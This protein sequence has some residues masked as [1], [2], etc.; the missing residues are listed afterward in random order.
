MFIHQ[1]KHTVICLATTLQLSFL[2]TPS[3]YFLVIYMSLLPCANQAWDLFAYQIATNFI[4]KTIK[5]LPKGS[6]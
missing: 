4:L 6:T 5:K 3:K 1:I 2:Y